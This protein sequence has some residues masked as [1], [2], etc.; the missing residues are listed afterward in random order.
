[1]HENSL[2]LLYWCFKSQ[3]SIKGV[4]KLWLQMTHIFSHHSNG[5]PCSEMWHRVDSVQT[6]E[7][8]LNLK[9]NNMM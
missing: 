5:I 9:V 6:S 3:S 4:T 1:M 8:L 2:L 7:A